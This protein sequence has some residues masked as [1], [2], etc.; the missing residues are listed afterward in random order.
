MCN[1]QCNDRVGTGRHG[2][3]GTDVSA[4]SG[5]RL[6]WCVAKSVRLREFW[7]DSADLGLD[8]VG[9]ISPSGDNR[10]R[11]LSRP[12]PSTTRPSLRVEIS[13]QSA[14]LLRNRSA[15]RPCVTACVT[16]GTTRDDTGHN[17]TN[18]AAQSRIGYQGAV[19]KR[20]DRAN[21][22]Q[23]LQISSVIR[24]AKYNRLGITD[25]G[26]FQDHRHRPLGHPSAST[27]PPE[28]ARSVDRPPTFGSCVTASVT[29]GTMR[30]DPGRAARLQRELSFP[31]VPHLIRARAPFQWPIS[32][33]SDPHC[34]RGGSP[35]GTS[36]D[37]GEQ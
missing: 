24:W 3:R 27:F 14:R 29:N 26:G 20:L 30:D 25:A 18:F 6:S 36:V 17:R 13:P 35:R 1:R 10:F 23:I 5:D 21:F 33:Q 9:K 34:R 31:P 16:N 4:F 8:Q 2:T 15:R 11:R 7:P 19:R 22:G 28:F 12:P 32:I 37:R